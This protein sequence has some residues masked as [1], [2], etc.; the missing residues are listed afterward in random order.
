LTKEKIIYIIVLRKKREV[1]EM[2]NLTK[3]D[4]DI[5]VEAMSSWENDGLPLLLIGS[6]LSNAC[7]SKDASKEE[8]EK[9]KKE[10]EKRQKEHESDKKK[11]KEISEIIKCKLLNMKHDLDVV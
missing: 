11:K 4:L 3:E 8:K 5:L 7:L 1:K 10:D 6:L 2:K 9:A